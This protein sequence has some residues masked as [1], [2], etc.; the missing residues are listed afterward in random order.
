MGNE[1][2]NIVYKKVADLV[3][4]ENKSELKTAQNALK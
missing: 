1:R 3:P 2:M 4:Y